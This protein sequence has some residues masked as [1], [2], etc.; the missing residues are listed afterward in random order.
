MKRVAV[1]EA[2]KDPN[3]KNKY[4]RASGEDNICAVTQAYRTGTFF[5]EIQAL[6]KVGTWEPMPQE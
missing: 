6:V 3:K 5:Y 2:M 4:I 1:S